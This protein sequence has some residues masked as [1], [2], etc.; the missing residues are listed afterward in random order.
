MNRKPGR[1]LTITTETL[2]ILGTSDLRRAAGGVTQ[3]LSC[4]CKINTAYM[5]C[6]TF[7]AAPENCEI[8]SPTLKC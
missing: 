7:T 1:K 4:L 8:Q 2:R 3:L 5:A 6:G